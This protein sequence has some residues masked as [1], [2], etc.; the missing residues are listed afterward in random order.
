MRQ[1]FFNPHVALRTVVSSIGIMDAD[2]ACS[3][4]PSS[5]HY[6]WSAQ[7]RLCFYVEGDLIGVKKK[8][9]APFHTLTSSFVVGPQLSETYLDFGK[10]ALTA[11]ISFCAG[12]LQRLTGIPVPELTDREVDAS[13]IFGPEIALVE[14]QLQENPKP[15]AMAVILNDFLLRRLSRARTLLPFDHA[16]REMVQ[17]HGNLSIEKTAALSCLSRRQFERKSIEYLGMPPKLF[18][19]LTRFSKA[20]MFKE[21]HPQIPWTKIAYEFGYYDQMHLIHDFRNF[22]GYSPSSLD[23]ELAVSLK[24]VHLF[25][26]DS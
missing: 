20:Y 7:I 3:A 18:A 10:G 1:Y 17:H 5:Y 25:E 8:A 6:P 14:R 11:A 19:R 21:G 22:A 23:K 4:L 2:F 13:L 15:E 26:R 24:L 16:I 9:H 12:G